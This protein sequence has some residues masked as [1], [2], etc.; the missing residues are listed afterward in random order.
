MLGTV[1]GALVTSCHF[2]PPTALWVGC[3]CPNLQMMSLAEKGFRS[4]HALSPSDLSSRQNA[5]YCEW[6]ANEIEPLGNRLQLRHVTFRS[7]LNSDS[8]GFPGGSVVKNPPAN[9]G[10]MGLI[11]GLGRSHMQLSTWAATIEPVLQD[12]EPQLLKPVCPR[13]RAPRHEKPP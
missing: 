7:E 10:D 8:L 12:W 13:A 6:D 5:L 3:C 2:I 4:V 9:A 1:L 11:P